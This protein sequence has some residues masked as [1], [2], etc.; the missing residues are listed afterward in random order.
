ML[1]MTDQAQSAVQRFVDT[2][3]KPIAGLRIAVVDG[4]CSGLQYSMSLEAGPQDGDS[5][6]KCGSMTVFV[7]PDSISVLDGTVIDFVENLQG[8]G[9]TF[10]NP[11]A[12][13]SC[14]CGKSF[15]A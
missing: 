13:K 11:N 6:V 9:F 1:E 3:D 5:V 15:G 12:T 8:S 2:A 10:E 14:N 4:G 7:E